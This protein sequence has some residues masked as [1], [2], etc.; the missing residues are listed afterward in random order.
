MESD[1]DTYG[2]K[3][4]MTGYGRAS[5]LT[6]ST[7]AD[8]GDL[9]SPPLGDLAYHPSVYPHRHL[10]PLSVHSAFHEAIHVALIAM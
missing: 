10:M 9:D 1:E 3:D 2:L 5:V 8:L 4:P 6:R 7:N